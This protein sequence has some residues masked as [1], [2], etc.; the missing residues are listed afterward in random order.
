MELVKLSEAYQLKDDLGNGW[1]ASGQVIK[2][3]SGVYRISL[4]ATKEDRFVGNYSYD[5]YPETQ[6]ASTHANCSIG[7]EDEFRGYCN[8]AIDQILEQLNVN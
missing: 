8:S 4:T 7:Y 5:L 1:V 3:Q 6:T 2:E